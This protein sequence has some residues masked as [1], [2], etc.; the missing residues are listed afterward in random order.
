MN[1][2]KLQ[3]E[4]AYKKLLALQGIIK[5]MG[6]VLIAFSG[7]VDSTFLLNVAQNVLGNRVIAATAQSATYPE[8]EYLDA[9][10]IAKKLH[11][12]HI[13]FNSDEMSCSDFVA[14][15]PNRCYYCKKELFT[16]LQEIARKSGIK[17]IVDGTNFSDKSDY[18]PGRAALRELGIRSP[19]VEAHLTKDD[20][21]ALSRKM[22]LSTAEKPSFA[23]LASRLP[24]GEKI[25]REKLDRVNKAETLLR[26]IG[27]KEVRVRDYGTLARIEIGTKDKLSRILET[28]IRNRLI[29]RLKKLGYIYITLDLE[30][31]RTG[32][33]NEILSLERDNLG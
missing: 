4:P 25:T 15:P 3:T 23:C 16:K 33:M 8:N 13:V 12:K 18:R 32:S 30:G 31:Y 2:T 5:E 19:L 9:K 22:H 28:P 1:Y 20:I 24:Y 6:S 27:F 11:V 26:E 7:G 17:H 21:R 10:R 14:N 29:R